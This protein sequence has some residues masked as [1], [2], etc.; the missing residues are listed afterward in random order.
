MDRQS[1]GL[2]W[3][4]QTIAFVIGRHET[5]DGESMDPFWNGNSAAISQIIFETTI[6]KTMPI[7]YETP[8]LP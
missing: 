1:N 5:G 4:A 7:I 2:Y 8:R 3:A 6:G